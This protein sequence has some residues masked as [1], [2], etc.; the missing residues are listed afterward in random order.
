MFT[1]AAMS[2]R[3]TRESGVSGSGA[4]VLGTAGTT[5]GVDVMGAGEGTVT[6]SGLRGIAG[7]VIRGAEALIELVADN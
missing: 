3:R 6:G 5:T 7:G 1:L 4:G 2:E